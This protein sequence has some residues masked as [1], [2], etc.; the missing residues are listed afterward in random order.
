MPERGAS[1]SARPSR[2]VFDADSEADEGFRAWKRR[3]DAEAANQ[4]QARRRARAEALGIA[5]ETN[6][7]GTLD[8]AACVMPGHPDDASSHEAAAV[9]SRLSRLGRIASGLERRNSLRSASTGEAVTAEELMAMVQ[10][11]VEAAG[12]RAD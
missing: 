1:A 11:A 9:Q 5:A 4:R 2:P 7:V 10:R 6:S 12:Q 3:K 8:T